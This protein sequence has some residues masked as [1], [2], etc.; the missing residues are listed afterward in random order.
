MFNYPVWL[1]SCSALRGWGWESRGIR[2]RFCLSATANAPALLAAGRESSAAAAGGCQAVILGASLL[3][4]YS[5]GAEALS[6]SSAQV[7][8]LAH[9]D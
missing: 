5:S 7:Y 4:C 1:Y 6:L 9:T 3:L 2:A 8:K